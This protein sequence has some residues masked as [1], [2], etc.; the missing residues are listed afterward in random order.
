LSLSAATNGPARRASPWFCGAEAR[1]GQ[2]QGHAVVWTV[3]TSER[4]DGMRRRG[5]LW[6]RA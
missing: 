1:R 2:G 5:L 4:E 6:G 3:D